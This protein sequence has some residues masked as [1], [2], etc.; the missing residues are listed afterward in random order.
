MIATFLDAPLIAKVGIVV[1]T[2]VVL[3]LIAL[4]L[5]AYL[6]PVDLDDAD[7]FCADELP[8][9]LKENPHD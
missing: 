5:W 7:D 4:L 9:C 2:L 6:W 1:G 8:P 3:P